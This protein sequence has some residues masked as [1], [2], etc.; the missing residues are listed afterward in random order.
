MKSCSLSSGPL[1]NIPFVKLSALTESL[2]ND[3]REHLETEETRLW[4]LYQAALNRPVDAVVPIHLGKRAQALDKQLGLGIAAIS[5]S[6]SR[7]SEKS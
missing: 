7:D 6:I 3:L 5:H 2:I 1:K 4:P